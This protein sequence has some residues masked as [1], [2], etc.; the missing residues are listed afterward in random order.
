MSRELAVAMADTV[1]HGQAIGI[2]GDLWPDF[3]AIGGADLV[4]V[5]TCAAPREPH[6]PACPLADLGCLTCEQGLAVN[7]Y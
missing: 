3:R 7:A 2:G 1:M 6:P 4:S 5:D